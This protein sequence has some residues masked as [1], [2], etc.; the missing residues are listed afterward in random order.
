MFTLSH[1]EKERRFYFIGD[2]LYALCPK[3][4]KIK[5]EDWVSWFD[6]NASYKLQWKNDPDR[7]KEIDGLI[8]EWKEILETIWT[9]LLNEPLLTRG[10]P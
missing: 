5:H 9:P 4:T 7:L 8:K 3:K 10:T 2:M 1:P 6:P